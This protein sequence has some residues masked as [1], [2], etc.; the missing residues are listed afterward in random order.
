MTS[1]TAAEG[2]TA[3][4]PFLSEPGSEGWVPKESSGAALLGI[5]EAPCAKKC[6]FCRSDGDGGRKDVDAR[7][8]VVTYWSHWIMCVHFP[9]HFEFA[10]L[11]RR[12]GTLRNQWLRDLDCG[13]PRSE[14]EDHQLI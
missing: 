11:S 8:A 14:Y 2:F 3:A 1:P 10:S 13:Q 4:F 12:L 6:R 5:V 7:R 9:Q